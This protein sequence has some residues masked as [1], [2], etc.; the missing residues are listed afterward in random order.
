[1]TAPAETVVR[2]R[3]GRTRLLLRLDASPPCQGRDA[4]WEAGPHMCRSAE[5][6]QGRAEELPGCRWAAASASTNRGRIP[7]DAVTAAGPSPAHPAALAGPPVDWAAL[8]RVL[9]V[10][11]DNLGDVVLTGPLIRAVRAVLRPGATLDLLA[12][13]GGSAVAPL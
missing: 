3:S 13:P 9:V 1:M 7:V 8:D 5:K 2:C 4:R 10:R 6:G 11:L 12:S